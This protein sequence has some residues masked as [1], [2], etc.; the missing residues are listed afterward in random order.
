MPT[1]YMEL[2]FIINLSIKF[3]F[4]LEIKGVVNDMINNLFI[5]LGQIDICGV[6]ILTNI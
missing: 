5:I 4:N 6:R 2:A 3:N 1:L